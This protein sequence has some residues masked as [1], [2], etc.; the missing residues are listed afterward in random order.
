LFPFSSNDVSDLPVDI[1]TELQVFSK[2]YWSLQYDQFKLWRTGY[3]DW[4]EYKYWIEGKKRSFNKVKERPSVLTVDAYVFRE[5]WEESKDR[6]HSPSLDNPNANFVGFRDS[7][8]IENKD[9]DKLMAE[10]RY[11][12][13]F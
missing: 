11:T 1:R 13:Y 3:V 5:G 2:R 4:K 6:W 8:L 7:L 9:I 10:F 12:F